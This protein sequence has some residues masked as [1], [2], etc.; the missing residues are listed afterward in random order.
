MRSNKCVD[1][2]TECSGQRCI[3][4]SNK[5]RAKKNRTL[6]EYKIWQSMKQR[7][8]NTN[9]STYKYYGGRGIS[10]CTEWRNSFDSFLR[11]IGHRPSPYHQ[12]DRIDN[13]KGYSKDNCRWT[14]RDENLKNRSCT[15]YGVVNGEKLSAKEI[16]SKYR[17]PY[18]AVK[19]RL[20]AGFTGADLVS[21]FLNPQ[22]GDNNNQ[23]KLTKSKA[24]EIR[25]K[26]S[27][28]IFST[29]LAKEYGVSVQTILNVVNFKTWKDA[30]I[31]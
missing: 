10:V 8:T 16:S 6:P 15:L 2:K 17:L 4:C 20:K 19:F 21:P 3:T 12:I 28:G 7:C 30:G 1:C 9:R 14:T 22:N 25:A 18:S 26:Y 27:N 11:D 23:A 29:T 24:V 5:S 31:E 13:N